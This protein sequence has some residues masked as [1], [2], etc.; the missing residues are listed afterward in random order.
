MG[1]GGWRER[2]R[3]REGKMIQGGRFVMRK[4]G[5]REQRMMEGRSN[6]GGMEIGPMSVERITEG[7]N[8]GGWY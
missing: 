3:E 1:G 7:G 2:S 4:G 5:R 6:R 8:V